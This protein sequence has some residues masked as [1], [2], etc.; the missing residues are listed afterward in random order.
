MNEEPRTPEQFLDLMIRG[1][2]DAAQ[3]AMESDNCAP[4]KVPM[5]M[6]N[7]E[8][9]LFLVRELQKQIKRTP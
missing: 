5:E 3:A 4:I 8:I 9:P 2:S 7:W 1:V 6:K